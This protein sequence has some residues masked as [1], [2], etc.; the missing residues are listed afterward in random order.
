MDREVPPLAPQAATGLRRP[1]IVD[2]AAGVVALVIGAVG[3]AVVALTQEPFWATPD[4]RLTL[5]FFAAAVVA[6]GV[7][8]ARRE[9]GLAL[10]LAGLGLAAAAMVL[11]WFL[12]TA[13]IVGVT[14][15]VIL[16]LSQ[17][18]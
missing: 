18:M 15:V 5:P 3:Y 17:V 7:A 14:A 8:V 9:R 2:H 16:I 10:P 13:I 12:L 1:W 4:W 6:T 11:G